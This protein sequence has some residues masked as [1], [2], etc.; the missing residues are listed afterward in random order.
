VAAL[1]STPLSALSDRFGRVR[2]IA[3]GWI[4]YA[5]LYAGMGLYQGG[6]AW[7]WLMLP[8]YG[9]VTAAIEGSEKAM[10]AD[11]VPA[12]RAG[13]AFG[14]YYLVSGLTLL[15]ASV[16]FGTLWQRLGAGMA[17]GFAAGCAVLASV[18]LLAGLG[19]GRAP[20]SAAGNEPVTP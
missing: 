2:V 14:W 6:V 8:L 19:L 11:L 5:L 18:V 16:V 4:A 15:P 9:L 7:L 3:F 12:G 10:V 20:Q 13:T 1:A 17:F